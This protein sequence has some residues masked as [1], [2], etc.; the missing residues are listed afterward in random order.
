M[1]ILP[2]LLAAGLL[3]CST[4]HVVYTGTSTI[5]GIELAQ[6]PTSQLYQG[7][8]G[9]NRTEVAVIPTNRSGDAPASMTGEGAKDAVPVLMELRAG[10]WFSFGSD[11]SIYQRLAVGSEAVRQPGAA[12]MMG[13]NLDGKLDPGTAAAISDSFKSLPAV[14]PQINQ[15]KKPL[16]QAY[17]ASNRKADFDTVTKTAGYASF[18]DFI[19]DTKTAGAKVQEVA[20]KLKAAGLIQ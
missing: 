14:N 6:N 7:K 5:I 8:L 11:S 4:R 20:D 19:A 2:C 17:A 9:Y 18:A 10:G 12:M 15:D 13:K 3:G 1:K 16:A